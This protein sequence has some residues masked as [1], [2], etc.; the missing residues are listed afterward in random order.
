MS[1]VAPKGGEAEFSVPLD[2]SSPRSVEWWDEERTAR[3]ID[4][5]TGEL[6]DCPGGASDIWVTLYVGRGGKV[7]SVGFASSAK[8]PI[9]DEWADCAA[10]KAASWVLSDPR[11]KVAKL[12]FRFNP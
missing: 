3:E 11:G 6:G 9:A 4:D 7:T 1:F 2:F 12:S 10:G 8:P 5:V